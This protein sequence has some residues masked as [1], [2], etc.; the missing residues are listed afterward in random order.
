M[1]DGLTQ[2]CCACEIAFTCGVAPGALGIPVPRLD[3]KL[4]VLAVADRLP[5]GGQNL[6]DRRLYESLIGCA[7][8]KPVDPGTQGLRGHDRIRRMARRGVN[9]NRLSV[10]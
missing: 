1:A 10:Q 8:R 5:S 3:V 9:A 2:R 4:R 7:W 6:L